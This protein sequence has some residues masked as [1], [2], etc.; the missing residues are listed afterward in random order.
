MRVYSY[1][2]IKQYVFWMDELGQTV[3]ARISRNLDSTSAKPFSWDISHHWRPSPGAGFY[4]PSAL[5]AITL[6]NAEALMLA[7]AKSFTSDVIGNASF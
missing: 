5:S 6:E 2:V 1:E 4:F 7:Y 3:K